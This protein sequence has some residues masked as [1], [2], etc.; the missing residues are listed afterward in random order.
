M[1]HDNHNEWQGLH[2]D[3]AENIW[4]EDVRNVGG[5]YGEGGEVTTT[6]L[7]HYRAHLLCEE[8]FRFFGRLTNEYL[9]NMFT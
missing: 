3:A 5:L 1:S 2:L 8:C 4:G 9:I 6:Q 7:W